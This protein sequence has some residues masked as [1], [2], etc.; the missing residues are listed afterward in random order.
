MMLV[1][2]SSGGD[3]V[4]TDIYAKN[5]LH[6]LQRVWDRRTA[7]NK[8]YAVIYFDKTLIVLDIMKFPR[9]TTYSQQPYIF[10]VAYVWCR[11]RDYI[12]SWVQFI[13]YILFDE[14]TIQTRPS[15]NVVHQQRL[16]L[17]SGKTW[18]RA[19]VSQITWGST[20]F[21]DLLQSSSWGSID[22]CSMSSSVREHQ[23]VQREKNV[24]SRSLW[25]WSKL[26]R[27]FLKLDVRDCEN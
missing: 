9:A 18:K 5:V 6:M 16:S 17:G 8:L 1:K 21:T 13:V 7:R 3:I 23:I 12:A 11:K 27:E 22:A 2:L 19:L 26:I 15:S 25:R 4:M 14:L 20:M 24:Y 10:G